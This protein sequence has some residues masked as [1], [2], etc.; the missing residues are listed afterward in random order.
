[1]V[2]LHAGNSHNNAQASEGHAAPDDAELDLYSGVGDVP[3]LS[4]GMV[5]G[6]VGV[7][8]LDCSGLCLC[9]SMLDVRSPSTLVQLWLGRL[10]TCLRL[11]WVVDQLHC[12]ATSWVHLTPVNVK[13]RR[14]AHLKASCKLRVHQID[15]PLA[16]FMAALCLCLLIHAISQLSVLALILSEL[17]CPAVDARIK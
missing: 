10:H 5:T 1:M 12:M 15:R 6:L 8:V 7:A 4:A 16:E 17:L 13:V 2:V 11:P 9:C 3:G 14:A